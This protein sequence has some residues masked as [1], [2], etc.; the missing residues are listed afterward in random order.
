MFRNE[1]PSSSEQEIKLLTWKCAAQDSAGRKK[2]NTDSWSEIAQTLISL[3]FLPRNNKGC[4]LERHLAAIPGEPLGQ[5]GPFLES[6]EYLI[7]GEMASV[8][9]CPTMGDFVLYN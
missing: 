8:S 4:V 7:S 2:G 3:K 5:F 9:Q 6:A 1:V